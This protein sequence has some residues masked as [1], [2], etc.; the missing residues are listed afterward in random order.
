M[1]LPIVQKLHLKYSE[2]VILMEETYNSDTEN[3]QNIIYSCLLIY[4][5]IIVSYGS[6]Y[7]PKTQQNN[8]RN[9][10]AKLIR[11]EYLEYSHIVQIHGGR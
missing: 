3:D 10:Q 5:F 8:K 2:F 1:E 6:E 11:P 4:L 9:T 7:L